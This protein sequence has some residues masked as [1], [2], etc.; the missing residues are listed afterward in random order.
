MTFQLRP[1]RVVVP[2][3][4]RRRRRQKTFTAL[5][6]GQ[7]L[8]VPIPQGTRPGDTL[9]MHAPYFP[10]EDS[11]LVSPRTDMRRKTWKPEK[12]RE[13][14]EKLKQT[15]PGVSSELIERAGTMNIDEIP[16]HLI[17]PITQDIFSDPVTTIDGHTYDRAGIEDWFKQHSTSPKTNQVLP[18]KLL[19]P[20]R[21]MRSRII[22][23]LDHYEERQPQEADFALEHSD[24]SDQDGGLG[25]PRVSVLSLTIILNRRD[26]TVFDLS[27]IGGTKHLAKTPFSVR[28]GHV[29]RLVISFKVGKE[30]KGLTLSIT[31]SKLDGSWLKEYRHSFGDF[32]PSETPNECQIEQ[33]C[34]DAPQVPGQY[35]N[36]FRLYDSTGEPHLQCSQQFI[37]KPSKEK[38]RQ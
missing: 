35:I 26:P 1:F 22:D 36:Q 27:T 14:L 33:P 12:W 10:N 7:P 11:A 9:I 13:Y 5:L 38:E 37:V 8:V 16:D 17:C 2:D 30:V 29:Y 28:E 34:P 15:A 19:V 3:L 24:D 4:P 6:N 23:F 20:N 31:T 25:P 21:A 18:S 32:A